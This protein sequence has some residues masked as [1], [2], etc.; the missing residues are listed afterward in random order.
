M[1]SKQQFLKVKRQLQ[2]M[3]KKLKLTY[4]RRKTK[5]GPLTTGFH[6]LGL[7]FNQVNQDVS[8][9][10]EQP[11]APFVEEVAAQTQ[12]LVKSHVSVILHE[13]CCSRSLEKVVVM[14]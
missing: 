4:S 11:E 9:L 10:P 1:R 3:L 6:F 8:A 2:Q 12:P 14:M 7:E 5:M 13:R